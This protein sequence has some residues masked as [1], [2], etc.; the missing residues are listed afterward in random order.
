MELSNNELKEYYYGAY[1]F[2]ETDD[3]YLQAFQ[4]T[5]EQ[6]D[7]FKRVSD[8]WYERCIASTAK[9]LEFATDATEFSFDYKITWKG[10]LDTIEMS[11]D[12]LITK[13]CYLEKLSD[14]GSLSFEL[15]E[16]TKNVTVYL[17]ADAL[18]VIKN[19]S[20]NGKLSK[21]SKNE[22]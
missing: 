7:Y 14:E 20:I 22:K 3:G 17:P 21:V 6:V 2:K 9:T 5:D 1:S 11:V 8:F 19:F 10:S 12:G 16:G 4:Y 18:I 13:I 15:S